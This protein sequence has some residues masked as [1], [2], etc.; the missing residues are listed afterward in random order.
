MLKI[1]KI[2]K[3]LRNT[4]LIEIIEKLYEHSEENKIFL[5]TFFIDEDKIE[6]Y[7]SKQL[8]EI[9]RTFWYRGNL[10][11]PKYD[12]LELVF[13]KI[14]SINHER[15]RL[16]CCL[17]Y[18]NE[19]AHYI[20]TIYRVES[21]YANLL[22]DVLELCVNIDN[23]D[24]ELIRKYVP[25]ILSY[26]LDEAFVDMEEIINYCYMLTNKEEEEE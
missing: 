22:T 7:R 18:A 25:K 26:D 12:T 3:S 8:I 16:E 19:L 17:V 1:S 10:K 24:Q 2:L 13:N 15:T 20:S 14:R 6:K 5:E 4:E 11:T 21:K 23:N 9:E